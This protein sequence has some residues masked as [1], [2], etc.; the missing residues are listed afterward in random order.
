MKLSYKNNMKI[1]NIIF[2]G[3]GCEGKI[4]IN[5]ARFTKSTT[6][7]SRKNYFCH[8]EDTSPNVYD[9]LYEKNAIIESRR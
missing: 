7:I 4:T 2:T 3:A 8:L 9:I 5:T 6:F 1:L